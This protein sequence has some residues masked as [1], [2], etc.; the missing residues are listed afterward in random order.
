MYKTVYT[1][2]YK[3]MRLIINNLLQIVYSRRN[4]YLDLL[5]VPFGT[6]PAPFRMEIRVKNDSDFLDF[7]ELL[8]S[9]GTNRHRCPMQ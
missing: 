7:F 2:C 3:K 6:S 9:L 5:N 8:S 4:Y 1:Q